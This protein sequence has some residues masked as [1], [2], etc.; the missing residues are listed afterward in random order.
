MQIIINK[1]LM[2][3]EYFEKVRPSQYCSKK[4]RRRA[5]SRQKL[6]LPINQDYFTK[7]CKFCGKEFTTKKYMQLY[8]NDECRYKINLERQK[9]YQKKYRDQNKK[10]I[11]QAPKI[12]PICGVEFIGKRSAYCSRKCS[13]QASYKMQNVNGKPY[14][15][16]SKA[17]DKYRESGKLLIEDAKRAKDEGTSYGKLTSAKYI[18]HFDRELRRW[19]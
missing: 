1:C 3:G 16:K 7:T 8:C 13:N 19:V 6:G 5:I 9:P 2:C 4:C 17:M 10:S 18:P 11:D 15:H 12:C 14:T